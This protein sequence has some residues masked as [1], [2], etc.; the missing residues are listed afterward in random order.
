LGINENKKVDNMDTGGTI[1][2]IIFVLGLIW[3]VVLIIALLNLFRRTDKS[4]VSKLIWAFII[5]SAPVLGLLL[6]LLVGNRF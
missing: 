3:L 5:V 6:Y 1:F 4:L 2:W